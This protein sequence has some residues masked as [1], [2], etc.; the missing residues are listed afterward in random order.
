M[1]A[2]NWARIK[3]MHKKLGIA[4]DKMRNNHLRWFQHVQQG[5]LSVLKELMKCL[6][7]KDRPRGARIGA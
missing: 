4:H 6:G 3:H 5:P 7:D 2:K 1:S